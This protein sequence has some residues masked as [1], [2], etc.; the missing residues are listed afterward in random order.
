MFWGAFLILIGPRYQSLSENTRF[1]L[2]L[3][4]FKCRSIT[5][6][7][8]SESDWIFYSLLFL[9]EI[10]TSWSKVSN[11]NIYTRSS[12]CPWG[13]RVLHWTQ[14]SSWYYLA[15]RLQYFYPE[16]IQVHKSMH[17]FFLTRSLERLVLPA[18]SSSVGMAWHLTA[19]PFRIVCL[20]SKS[21]AKLS[22]WNQRLSF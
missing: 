3:Y 21:R 22:S 4:F 18:G 15:T 1:S 11:E 8:S 9:K 20:C 12:H 17:V 2:N 10:F 16:N 19:Q 7:M 6:K 13:P 5:A 14:P